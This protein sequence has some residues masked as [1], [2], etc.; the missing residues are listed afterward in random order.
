MAMKDDK[1]PVSQLFVGDE[2]CMVQH[3]RLD[4]GHLREFARALRENLQVGPVDT[5]RIFVRSLFRAHND[6]RADTTEKDIKRRLTRTLDVLVEFSFVAV[7]DCYICASHTSTHY[8][9]APDRHT[10]ARVASH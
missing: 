8:S 7:V 2:Q 1:L 10:P 3:R 4:V 5:A 9:P 6:A